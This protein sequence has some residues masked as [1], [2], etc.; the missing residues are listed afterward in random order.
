MERAVG[1]AHAQSSAVAVVFDS[2]LVDGLDAIETKCVVDE[3]EGSRVVQNKGAT[4]P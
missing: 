2:E 4:C 3:I 1:H